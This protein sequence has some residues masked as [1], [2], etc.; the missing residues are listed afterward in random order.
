MIT[1][2][3]VKEFEE[4]GAVTIDGEFTPEQIAAAA[5]VMDR[6]LVQPEPEPGEKIHYR[7]GRTNCFYDPALLELIQ[8]PFIEQIAKRTLTADEVEFYATA[9]VKSFP[10]PGADRMNPDFEKV[11]RKSGA[12]V[13]NLI[14][15]RIDRVVPDNVEAVENADWIL[16]ASSQTVRN[17]METVNG[18]PIRARV[19]CIGPLT[20]RTARK[21]GLKVVAVPRKYTFDALVKEVL[22]RS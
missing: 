14:L 5:E 15:Y 2:E 17:F 11:L 3:Q 16:F 9:I 4:L 20:A 13:T 21:C 6:L 8:H 19:A 1:D 12:R 18:R 22:K 10:H 7:V